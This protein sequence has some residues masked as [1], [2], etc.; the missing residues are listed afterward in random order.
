MQSSPVTTPKTKKEYMVATP[1]ALEIFLILLI[2]LFAAAVH[3]YRIGVKAMTDYEANQLK[4]MMVRSVG[5]GTEMIY[6]EGKKTAAEGRYLDLG[7]A[8]EKVDAIDFASIGASKE[9][10]DGQSRTSVDLEQADL[11][12]WY[13]VVRGNGRILLVDSTAGTSR[14]LTGEETLFLKCRE[15]AEGSEGIQWAEDGSYFCLFLQP[16]NGPVTY[17][18]SPLLYNVAGARIGMLV[19]GNLSFVDDS[20]RQRVLGYVL[21][22]C[23]FLLIF[24]IAMCLSVHRYLRV[25]RDMGWIMQRYRLLQNAITEEIRERLAIV[26]RRSKDSELKDL[27]E[28]FYAMACNLQDYWETVESIKSKYEPFAP[29]ALLGLLRKGDSLDVRPGDTAEV[30]GALL[31]VRLDPWEPAD[32]NPLCAAVCEI[33][34]SS[35]GI[36]VRTAGSGIEAIFPAAGSDAEDLSEA[37]RAGQEASD[38][39]QNLGID[40][41]DG[42]TIVTKVWRGVFCL[43]VIGSEKRMDVRLAGKGNRNAW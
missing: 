17:D 40:E 37:E 25:L 43:R 39:I 24:I 12:F 26:R 41:T 6:L 20:V 4:T 29:E 34:S 13:L 10:D 23:G 1:A 15:A 8:M 3:V 36:I 33:I 19:K 16:L 7:A 30:A 5:T 14:E 21:A 22:L 11:Q 42:V 9:D 2:P 31:K 27:V 35:G 38:Q 28:S 32:T 18:G